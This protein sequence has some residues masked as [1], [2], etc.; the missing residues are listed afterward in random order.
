V[1]GIGRAS[2]RAHRKVEPSWSAE[3]VNLT[4]VLSVWSASMTGSTESMVVSGG[5]MISQA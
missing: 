2:S 3:K 1:H 5:A 4:S